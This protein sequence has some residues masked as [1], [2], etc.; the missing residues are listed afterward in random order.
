MAIKKKK[1]FALLVAIIFMSVMLAFGL[2][3]GSFAYKQQILASSAIDSQYAFY[4][5]DAA[6]E[7]A[8]YA[9]QGN[10]QNI[11]SYLP[12]A[13]PSP[14]TPTVICNDTGPISSSATWPSAGLW[15]V[16][17]RM[18][19]DNNARCADIT[20]YKYSTPQ[21]PNSITTYIFSQGYSV[22]CAKVDAND[23]TR[24]SSRG[25]QVHY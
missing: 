25:I 22:S 18:S 8:L 9:D 24:F 17:N 19:L 2:V 6:M 10:N 13:S 15:V 14:P 21:P 5:A 12:P 16:K 20:V 11:F 4:A 23:G 3:L 7:C 1:G